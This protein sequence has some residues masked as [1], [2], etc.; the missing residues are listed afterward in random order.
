MAA[1]I[2]TAS[3]ILHLLTLSKM[4]TTTVAPCYDTP[5]HLDVPNDHGVAITVQHVVAFRVSIEDHGLTPL[6]IRQCTKDTLCKDIKK[7]QSGTKQRE[8]GEK[9]LQAGCS[10]RPMTH[11]ECSSL[12]SFLLSVAFL[13]NVQ[14]RLLGLSML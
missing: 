14:S 1:A 11:L 5:T 9:R 10:Q 6:S 7:N 8:V 13:L 4:N 2:R 12:S 3:T